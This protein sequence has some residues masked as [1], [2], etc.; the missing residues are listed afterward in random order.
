MTIY[1]ENTLVAIHI[2]LYE[3]DQ[4]RYDWQHYIPL[5]DRK[6]G[7]LRNGAP[8]AEMPLPLLKLQS[9]LR[10][11]ERLMGD[12]I[13]ATVLA[14]VPMHGLEAVL[15]AVEQVLASGA[16]SAEQDVYKR[17]GFS[18]LITASVLV[19]QSYSWLIT[20]AS[21]SCA[22]ILMPFGAAAF[23]LSLIHI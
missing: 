13:M 21:N 8:F 5:I 18:A 23:P 22:G 7:A 12:R 15:I 9:E 20:R 4:T 16:P 2:R 1:A 3:R 17:Q 19:S 11:R 14:N 6:P 10:R